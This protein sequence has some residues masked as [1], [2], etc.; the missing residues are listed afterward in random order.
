MRP[1]VVFI[2]LLHRW[3]RLRD[4]YTASCAIRCAI[5]LSAADVDI[6]REESVSLATE[7]SVSQATN[8]SPIR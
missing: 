8:S 5:C 7:P 6:V 1:S 4:A 3:F 2:Q